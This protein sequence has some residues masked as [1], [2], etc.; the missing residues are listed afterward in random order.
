VVAS[1]EEVHTTARHVADTVQGL[2]RRREAP[3]VDAVGGIPMRD[4]RAPRE[5][6]AVRVL[7]FEDG[8]TVRW[9]PV[10]TGL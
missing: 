7:V 4:A 5:G 6:A 8:A 9:S 2:T 3:V 1:L 10:A